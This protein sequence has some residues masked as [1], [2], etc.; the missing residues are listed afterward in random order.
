MAALKMTEKSVSDIIPSLI[1][2]APC[3]HVLIYSASLSQQLA[4]QSENFTSAKQPNPN[5]K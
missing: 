1:Q 3:N 5:E 2:I 4:L